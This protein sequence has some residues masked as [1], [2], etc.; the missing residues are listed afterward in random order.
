MA[1]DLDPTYLTFCNHSLIEMYNWERH[2]IFCFLFNAC[3][4]HPHKT[5][6]ETLISAYKQ[7][8][9]LWEVPTD[10]VVEH[11]F[12][13]INSKT[14]K[15]NTKYNPAQHIYRTPTLE[16]EDK[17]ASKDKISKFIV[18]LESTWKH[19][20]PD[21]REVP[22][23]TAND[24]VYYWNHYDLLGFILSLLKTDL[25][26][27]KKDNFFLPLTA[28]YGRWCAKIG[29]DRKT[30]DPSE[31]PKDTVL[32]GMADEQIGVGPVPT[33]FQCTWIKDKGV[34]YF[35]LGS[36]IAGHNPN[37]NNKSEVG[38]WKEK[39]QKTRFDLLYNWND[40]HTERIDDKEWDFENS[41]TLNQNKRAGTHFG[42]CGETYPFLHIL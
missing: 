3:T 36:S 27:A 21:P 22:S 8:L 23:L 39:L 37:W 18:R 25:E 10:W 17:K 5:T 30:L 7:F 38:V 20:T 19:I 4:T 31:S 13:P 1:I 40:I 12:K 14:L 32:T 26:G 2:E 29:G 16:W 34:V 11:N 15:L 9:S 35:A 24:G 33:V 41:P 6:K 42:N 28:V